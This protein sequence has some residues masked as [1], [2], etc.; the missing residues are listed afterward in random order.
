[1]VGAETLMLDA[2]V[3]FRPQVGANLQ[4][5]KLS[6]VSATDFRAPVRAPRSFRR[7]QNYPGFFWL[8]TTQS[9]QPYESLLERDRLWLADF[10]SKVT[11][12]V[13]QPVQ[14]TVHLEGGTRRHVPDFLFG[15]RDGSYQ[16]VDVKPK[17]MLGLQ[18]V[19]TQFAWTG[20]ACRMMGWR[21]EVWSGADPILL[22]NI[23]FIAVGRRPR[24][25]GPELIDNVA[26]HGA[27][28][29]TLGQAE[30][31]A[32][33]ALGCP[34]RLPSMALLWSGRWSTDLTIPLSRSSVLL[35]REKE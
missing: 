6:E 7:Q 3:R 8:A 16:M 29:M 30:D 19:R 32:S 35:C 9:T 10:D 27:T 2:E 25:L 34:V 24:W 22:R 14:I 1:M 13:S 5:A 28:G 23:K 18:R 26:Q 12:V 21:Y 11:S 15:F 4:T 33:E 17:E 31:I 20:R